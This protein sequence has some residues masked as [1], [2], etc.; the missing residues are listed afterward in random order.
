MD[1]EVNVNV[2]WKIKQMYVA[3]FYTNEIFLKSHTFSH[4]K[5]FWVKINNGSN[6]ILVLYYIQS[7]VDFK[8]SKLYYPNKEPENVKFIEDVL[9]NSLHHIYKL[10]LYPVYFLRRNCNS[11]LALVQLLCIVKRK[12]PPTENVHRAYR[13]KHFVQTRLDRR[14]AEEMF[15][16]K[17]NLHFLTH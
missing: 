2:M 16:Y 14:S 5:L 6:M 1:V 11:M 7:I 12:M 13:R 17:N 10:L 9:Y 15:T 4:C 3:D 8:R